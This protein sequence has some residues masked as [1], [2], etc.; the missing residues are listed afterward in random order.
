[1]RHANRRRGWNAC[2]GHSLETCRRGWPGRPSGRPGHPTTTPGAARGLDRR[3]KTAVAKTAPHSSIVPT[4]LGLVCCESC[5]SRLQDAMGV[6]PHLHF[7]RAT[8]PR[9]SN[10]AFGHEAAFHSSRRHATHH[11][12]TQTEP[13]NRFRRLASPSH[14]SRRA[15]LRSFHYYYAATRKNVGATSLSRDSAARATRFIL[16]GSDARVSDHGT[17]GR[18]ASDPIRRSRFNAVLK[19]ICLFTL[20]PPT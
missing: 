10:F 5:F 16:V 9:I 2:T 4:A 3:K 19:S 13:R 15:S 20:T 18:S 6:F 14:P 17:T 7:E 12:L 8:S 11:R 1:M